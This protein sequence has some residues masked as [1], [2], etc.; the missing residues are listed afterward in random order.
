[1]ERTLVL[2][3][4][5][6]VRRA[7]IG[8]V[9]SRFEASGLK[10]VGMKALVPD[11]DIVGRHY[12][13][14]E[15]WLSSVGSKARKSYGTED[16]RQKMSNSDIGRVI[17]NQLIDSLAG[18]PVVALVVEGNEVVFAVRKMAGGTEPKSADPSSI[19]SM[20]STDSY[21]HAD[22][23]K[24]P[25]RNVLHASED[26]GHADYEIALWFNSSEIVDYKRADED[27]L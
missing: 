13:D 26:K 16:E 8:R 12:P 1:M 24:R 10:I 5:D 19:R 27:M 9:I 17:R 23:S 22:E 21:T 11:R 3:K 6:G 2:V 14:D 18:E 25:L 4:P 15:S 7:L 20:Y